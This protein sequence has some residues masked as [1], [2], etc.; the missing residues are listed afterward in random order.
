[1]KKYLP[2]LILFLTMTQISLSFGQIKEIQSPLKQ[3]SCILTVSSYAGTAGNC[4]N[5]YSGKASITVTNGTLA[6]DFT[7]TGGNISNSV[8]HYNTSGKDSIT[9][10]I[11][12][13]YTVIV[14]DT[15]GCTTS[16]TIQIPQA[17][18]PTISTN[19][20][21]IACMGQ[22]SGKI[23]AYPSG[24]TPPYTYL[25]SANASGNTNSTISNLSAGVYSV[26][27]TD[28]GGCWTTTTATIIQPTGTA[29]GVSLYPNSGS[30]G[31]LGSISA[32]ISGGTAPYSYSW[33]N[34]QTTANTTGLSSGQYTLTVTDSKGCSIISSTSIYTSVGVSVKIN[35]TN[36]L[37]SSSPTGTATATPTG[38]V[39][40]Y[41]Y[42]WSTGSTSSS[43]TGLLDGPYTLTVSD[44]S[45][46]TSTSSISIVS[47]TQISPTLTLIPSTCGLN[48]GSISVQTTGGTG[49]YTYSWSNGQ[50]GS[51]AAGLLPNPYTVTVTDNNGCAVSTTSS[52]TSI[53]GPSSSLT[54]TSTT[55]GQANGKIYS[56]ITGGTVPYTYLWSNNQKSNIATNVSVGNYTL[57]VTDANGCSSTATTQVD[58][59]AVPKAT[60][61]AVTNVNCNG[62]ANGSLT[63]FALSGTAPYNYSWS[64]TANSNNSSATANNLV[65]GSYTVR[66]TDANSCIATAA[67]TITQPL[68]LDLKPTPLTTITCNNSLGTISTTLSGGSTPYTYL[69]STGAT[70]QNIT[71]STA[72]TYTITVTDNNGCSSTSTAI[73]VANTSAPTIDAAK[74]IVKSI[75]CN[76]QSDGAIT[77]SVSSTNDP[78]SFTW[79]AGA[80]GSANVNNLASGGYTVTITDNNS[81]CMA[82]QAFQ[83]TQPEKL[84]AKF[85]GS[86]GLLSGCN[87]NLSA[88]ASGGTSP[89]TYSW[90]NFYNIP[91]V[92]NVCP[93][94]YE[95]TIT[96]AGGC[97]AISNV[98][99]HL[100]SVSFPNP[101]PLVI[102]MNLKDASGPAVCDGT[103]NPF[104]SGGTPPYQF[105]YSDQL[106]TQT[107]QGLCPAVYTLKVTDYKGQKDSVSFV[108]SS[109][110]TTYVDSSKNNIAL[111]D[112]VIKATLNTNALNNCQAFNTSIDSIRIRD[113]NLISG[114]DSVDVNWYIF[115]KTAVDSIHQHYPIS[116]AGVYTV[117]LQLYCILPIA[118]TEAVAGVLKGVGHVYITPEALTTGISSLANNFKNPAA[119]VFPNPFNST[120]TIQ[121]SGQSKYTIQVYDITGNKVMENVN[122]NSTVSTQILDLS[123]LNAGTYL[124]NIVT[125]TAIEYHKLV[126]AN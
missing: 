25:W 29:L 125:P 94:N 113:Y 95:V 16:K 92:T 79:S 104:V 96:D 35:S 23:S 1:M 12:G 97:T 58:S 66:V 74:T 21:Q 62:G 119:L 57:T 41:T 38:G 78:L 65:V 60:I 75:S 42:G 63:V 36:P 40:P 20:T 37:C 50:T 109:P 13:S 22:S 54:P 18:S 84:S 19:T 69:W 44:Y 77:L 112:S 15:N 10:Y 83:V 7:W 114:T 81:G 73:V 93:G 48:N 51:I 11:A 6:Y 117:I 88:E 120:V 80:T 121:F 123:K 106:I 76:G 32:N 61:Q 126:K 67:A 5:S 28:A 86:T 49:A 87:G 4:S 91:V 124:L 52:V 99:L 68:A 55:C 45:G 9:G 72:G 111:T 31:A 70:T 43:V 103:A 53:S 26:T 24:G 85:T 64:G 118:K 110:K 90:S 47:P 98:T 101:T 17:S 115:H 27:L 105:L 56:T 102:Y 46:C 122:G 39:T 8:V 82:V 14:K 116:V 34:G 30:C 100:D 108:I 89:Y 3:G 107:H 71:A 59:I 33:N 2:F